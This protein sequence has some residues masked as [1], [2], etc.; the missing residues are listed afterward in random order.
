MDLS[1][2]VIMVEVI[3]IIISAVY[4]KLLQEL[5]LEKQSGLE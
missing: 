1:N 3:V 2:I 4:K 5:H